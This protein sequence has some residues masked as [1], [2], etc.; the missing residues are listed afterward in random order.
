MA[1]VPSSDSGT[2]FDCSQALD[3]ARHADSGCSQPGTTFD[4]TVYKSV[5]TMCIKVF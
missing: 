1:E 5:P 4:F 3:L 2:T